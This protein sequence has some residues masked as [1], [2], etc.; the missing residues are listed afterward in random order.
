[1]NTHTI[2]LYTKTNCPH[3]AEV[4]TLLREH[5]IEFEIRDVLENTDYLT[6]LTKKTGMNKT[7]SLEFDGVMYADTNV[8]DVEALL[9]EKGVIL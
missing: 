7:P 4:R 2:I 6:K 1:M 9:R 8:V 5:N 3:C